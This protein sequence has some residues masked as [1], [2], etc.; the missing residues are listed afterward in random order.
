MW[1]EP[2]LRDREREDKW[3]RRAKDFNQIMYFLT[4]I[5]WVGLV[6][7]LFLII[8]VMYLVEVA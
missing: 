3:E 8:V 4:L 6:F 2:E 1:W 5:A 7:P